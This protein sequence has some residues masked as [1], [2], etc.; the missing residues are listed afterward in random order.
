[1]APGPGART[2]V[3]KR[4]HAPPP[5]VEVQATARGANFPAGRMLISS[6]LEIDAIIRRIPAG[7]VVPLGRLRESL[8]RSHR[9]DYTCPLTTGIFLRVVAEAIEEERAAGR[10]RVAPYWRVVRDDGTLIDKLPGGVAAQARALSRDGIELLHVGGRPRVL[11]V[12]AIAWSPP[13]LGR[14]KPRPARRG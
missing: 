7:R 4:D 2:A 13:P 12:D 1:M 11:D 3:D 6:P 10:T 8:A 9:A 14:P 5:R